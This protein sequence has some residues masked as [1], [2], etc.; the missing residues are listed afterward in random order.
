METQGPDAGF[1]GMKDALGSGT[2]KGNGK[3]FLGTDGS[4]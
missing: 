4:V 1:M 3:A 2:L